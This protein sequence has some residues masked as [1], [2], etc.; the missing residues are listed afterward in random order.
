MKWNTKSQGCRFEKNFGDFLSQRLQKIF[1]LFEATYS[2]QVFQS[3]FLLQT[4]T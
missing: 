2:A 4:A 3:F 1:P